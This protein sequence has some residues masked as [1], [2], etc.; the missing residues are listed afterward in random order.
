MSNKQIRQNSLLA[1][2]TLIGWEGPYTVD[3]HISIDG[4]NRG[5][6]TILKRLIGIKTYQPERWNKDFERYQWIIRTRW[7][8]LLSLGLVEPLSPM[9]KLHLKQ[10][11]LSREKER[12][13]WNPPDP[14]ISR[15]KM[16]AFEFYGD[17]GS[18]SYT[19]P[20]YRMKRRL[21]KQHSHRFIGV[22]YK[23]KGAAKNVSLD[24]SPHYTNAYT[25]FVS[26]G[27]D[28]DDLLQLITSLEYKEN[29][30]RQLVTFRTKDPFQSNRFFEFIEVHYR[31][32]LLGFKLYRAGRDPNHPE[33]LTDQEV[34]FA[35]KS[36]RCK[37]SNGTVFLL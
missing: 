18:S 21:H 34:V 4:G 29:L 35:L 20:S 15:F 11:D 23:D 32:E 27:T 26:H 14:I 30:R 12:T 36:L 24:G 2:P 28:V 7:E 6:Q 3:L 25:G 1:A 19:L 8:E 5:I 37:K 31:G 16:N 33:C 9:E 13:C 17:L 22:G 10:F